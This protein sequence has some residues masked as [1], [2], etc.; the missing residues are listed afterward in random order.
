MFSIEKRMVANLD[1]KDVITVYLSK[2]YYNGDSAIFRLRSHKTG[3]LF[4]LELMSNSYNRELN[5]NVYK[6]YAKDIIIGNEY[7]VIDEWGL[8]VTLIY[9]GI[10]KTEWFD[11]T[12]YYDGDDLGATYTPIQTTF[13]VWAPVA[14]KVKIEYIQDNRSTTVRMDRGD[15]GVWSAIVPGDLDGAAYTYLVK[16][17]DTWSQATDPYGISS[18]PNNKKSVVLNPKKIYKNKSK[19]KLAPLAANVD[20]IIYEISVRDFTSGVSS[21]VVNRGKYLGMAEEGRETKMGNP[22]GLDYVKQ[23]GITHVQLMPIYDFATVDELNE[24]VYYNWGYDPMQYNVPEGSYSTDALNPYCRVNELKYAISK[25]HENGI[26]VNMDVVYNHMYDREQSSFEKIV[27]G[28]YFRLGQNGEISNGSFCGN[29]L[30]TKKLMTRKYIV[31]SCRYWVKQYG[32]DGFRF[33]LM[34]IIDVDTLNIIYNECKKI[35]SSFMMYG[36]GWNMPTLLDN[37]EKGMRENHGELPHIGFFNDVYRDIVKG[38]TGKDEVLSKGYGTG[39]TYLA[40]NMHDMLLCKNFVNDPNQ[41]INYYECHDNGTMWDKMK[42]SNKDESKEIRLAR[43]KLMH[44]ILAVSQ[45]VM[46]VHS[47][48]EFCRTKFGAHNTY[49]APDSIN[50]LDWDRKDRYLDQ[51][52]YMIDLIDLR[53]RYPVFRFKTSQEIEEHVSTRIIDY[54]M[55]Q[56]SISNV[57]EYLEDF[58]DVQIFINPTGNVYDEPLKADYRVILDEYGVVNEEIFTN[59]VTVE[60]YSMIVLMR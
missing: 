14:T 28:Y 16:N 22:T 20:A 47:G 58:E 30:D 8:T 5:C 32:I 15:K 7:D 44:G 23:L 13:K 40:D 48:E 24:W 12:Y 39:N 42:A 51:V 27:P 19:D 33:D 56:L 6:L 38:K 21:G 43:Q 55:I 60:P 26:R 4:S 29:D 50:H 34:G 53:K 52:E 2:N 35:D 17:N 46:F 18:T 11:Q 3:E 9:S 41:S 37:S 59:V 1:D 10:V 36:E 54:R 57:K 31:D 45:G 49:N 25:F